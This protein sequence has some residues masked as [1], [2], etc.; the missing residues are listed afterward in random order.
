MPPIVNNVTFT[1]PTLGQSGQ[2]PD[3]DDDGRAHDQATGTDFNNPR[4]M[5]WNVGVTRRMAQLGDRRSQLRRQPRRQPDSPDRHQLPAAGRGRRA[6]EH[7]G[8]RGQ[9]GAPVSVVRRDHVPRNHGAVALSRPADRR[10]DRGRQ[11]RQRHAELHAE[12]QPDRRHQ[13]SRRHRHPAE[14]GQ[15]RCGLCGRAHRSPA[16]LQRQLHL[17]AAVLPFDAAA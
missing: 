4:M 10:E 13:R 1:N 5:Q 16:H 17:R 14:P 3:A 8:R 11:Q 12:P 6:A 7:G 15:S 2:R 9:P